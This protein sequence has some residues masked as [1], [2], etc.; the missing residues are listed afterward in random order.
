MVKAAKDSATTRPT[1]IKIGE[2][3]VNV[4]VWARSH[5]GGA[6]P[7]E[8]FA[9]QDATD[10][11]G[12]IHS[13]DAVQQVERMKAV[14][15]PV[16]VAK[17]CVSPSKLT[18]AF[19]RFRDEVEREGFF[20]RRWSND[21]FNVSLTLVCVVAAFALAYRVPLVA[22]LLLGLGMQQ[23]GWVGHDYA[24]GRGRVSWWLTNVIS[25]L[26]NG[27]SHSWWANKHNTHHVHPNQRGVDDDIANDPILHLHVPA[28]ES[29][30]VWFRNYQ[31]IYYHFAYAFL[32]VSWRIQSFQTAWK[33]RNWAE[34]VP[35]CLNY[36]LLSYLPLSV[37]LGGILLGG[38]FV[39]EVVT[40]SHQSEDY[41]EHIDHDFVKNQ[42]T[43]TR[44]MA[45]DSL[46]WNYFW[47]GMQY[48]L[49]HHL[50]P[51]M[52][53]YYYPAMVPRIRAF[54]KANNIE[55]RTAGMWEIWR[56]NFETMKKFAVTPVGKKNH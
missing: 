55:Y 52:P 46:L 12:A 53:R 23:A 40:A 5:P 17:D 54:A 19:R 22:M 56:L 7:I 39:A 26:V 35:I 24:H 31:H 32:Y 50:F 33:A 25:S 6:A 4:S 11:F 34:L 51:T 29:S 10:A 48:Q 15:P 8:R 2:K 42:F 28:S 14:E 1:L 43:S 47:G 44:D 3:W 21:A 41:I 16:E 27:F 36:A 37:S 30:D 9:G 20:E 13:R 38:F 18:L 49:V 45:T